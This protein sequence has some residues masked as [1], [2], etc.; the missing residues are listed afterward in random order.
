[1]GERDCPVCM[2]V[3]IG[4]KENR[5]MRQPDDS[6]YEEAAE[7]IKRQ[8]KAELGWHVWTTLVY[9]EEATE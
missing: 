6:D 7:I 2:K 8:I 3:E 4:R 5:W 1:M 9:P